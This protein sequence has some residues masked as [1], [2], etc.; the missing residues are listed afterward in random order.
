MLVS[1]S[2]FFEGSLRY[3]RDRGDGVALSEYYS[4]DGNYLKR[5]DQNILQKFYLN[6][7]IN[8]SLNINVDNSFL[9]HQ[10]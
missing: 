5:F 10:V 7:R 4:L 3:V 1:G 8:S 9:D 2:R 6:T